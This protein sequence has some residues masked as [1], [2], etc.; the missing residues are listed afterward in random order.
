MIGACKP[1][2]RAGMVC[3]ELKLNGKT[4]AVGGLSAD[5]VVSA[6]VIRFLRPGQ[7]KERLE[8]E[9]SGYDA[10]AKPMAHLQWVKAAVR[11]GDT[12]TIRL[13]ERASADSPRRRDTEHTIG[14]MTPQRLR[15]EL[16]ATERVAAE[17]RRRLE[18]LESKDVVRT[19]SRRGRKP[20]RGK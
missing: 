20:H 3:L 12:V 11:P 6:R 15:Q 8:L 16:K 4:L 7:R 13:L 18:R 1:N 9:L 10:A 5:G 2:Y 19:A 14:T 17:L